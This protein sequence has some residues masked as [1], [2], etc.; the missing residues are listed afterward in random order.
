M[1]SLS[2]SLSLCL[3]VCMFD[4]QR[5][6]FE[7]VQVLVTHYWLKEQLNELLQEENLKYK[8]LL[9]LAGES[10]LKENEIKFARD[11]KI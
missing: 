5:L 6:L 7:R 3:F 9:H 10:K 8:F 11:F 1:P 4:V 2:L